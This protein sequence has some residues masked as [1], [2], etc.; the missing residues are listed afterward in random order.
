ML[1][2]IE[3]KNSVYLT[4]AFDRSR[5]STDAFTFSDATTESLLK[6]LASKANFYFNEDEV[7]QGIVAPQDFLNKKGKQTLGKNFIVGQGIFNIDTDEKNG[8]GLS[9]TEE[10]LVKPFYTSN[11]LGRYYGS[12]KNKL[13]VIYTSSKFKDKSVIAQYPNIKKHL[14][15]FTKII[16]SDNYP[17]GLHR[18]RDE[19]FFV[20]E[21]IVSLRKCAGPVFT[22]SDFPCYVS[23][24][25][26]VIKTPRADHLFLTGLLNSRLVK[27]WLKHKGK[28][29]GENFQVDKEPILSIP[30]R[31]PVKVEQE[32]LA[33]IIKKVIDCLKEAENAKTDNELQQLRRYAIQYETQF[34]AELEVIYELTD[35]ESAML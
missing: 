7:A 16:T 27:F 11:E 9:K 22:Y 10:V 23:Q 24:T 21:K 5:K 4:P 32:R 33:R 17:Y 28:M 25:F 26:N 1:E 14:D 34:Q 2:K 20:G 15:K 12:Q 31:L 30:L 35:I 3:L 13:W 19:R 8:L 6:K 29:Q 18:A